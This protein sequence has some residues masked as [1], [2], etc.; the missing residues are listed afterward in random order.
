MP[1]D[2]VLQGVAELNITPFLTQLARLEAAV[3]TTVANVGI[4]M[5]RFSASINTSVAGMSKGVAGAGGLTAGLNKVATEAKKAGDTSKQGA[6]DAQDAYAG[7]NATLGEHAAELKRI[8]DQWNSIYRAGAQISQVAVTMGVLGGA[9]L[10]AAAATIQSASSVDFWVAKYRAAAQAA[11][12]FMDNEQDR[13]KAMQQIPEIIRNM[14]AETGVGADIIAEAA[15]RYQ[16]AA[17]T[18]IR[19]VKELQAQ[20]SGL[21]TLVKAS[22][23]ADTDLY[24]SVRG[25]TQIMGSFNMSANEMTRVTEV[26]SNAAQ[27]SNAEFQEFVESGKYGASVAHQLGVSF[28]EYIAVLAKLSE[29]GQRGTRAGRGLQMMLQ[30]IIDPSKEASAA[31]QQILVGSDNLDESWRDLIFPGGQFVGLMDSVNESG[32]KQLGL[33]GQLYEGTKNMTEAERQRFLATITTQNAY[34]VLMPMLQAYSQDLKDMA[35][36]AETGIKAETMSLE[37]LKDALSDVDERSRSFTE[38]WNTIS[39]SSRVEWSKEFQRLAA[40]IQQIGDVAHVALLPLVQNITDIAIGIRQW[41]IEN[42]QA[43]AT[44]A[45]LVTSISALLLVM[46]PLLFMLG[47]IFQGFVAV[48]GILSKASI[49]ILAILGDTVGIAVARFSVLG[50]AL[51]LLVNAWRNNW[52]GLTPVLNT[53]KNLIQDTIGVLA[54]SITGLVR[55]VIALFEGDWQKAWDIFV[56]IGLTAIALFRLYLGKL[57]LEMQKWGINLIG[58]LSTGLLE[59]A[60]TVL[61]AVLTAIGNM[62]ASFF[63]GFSPPKEGPLSDIDRWGENVMGAYADGIKR[64]AEKRIKPA[65]QDAAKAM[66]GPLEGHSPAKEGP[67]AEIGQWGSN[68]MD[69]ML[70]GFKKADFSILNEAA[71][72]V[73]DYLKSAVEAKQLSPDAFLSGMGQIRSAIASMLDGIRKGGELAQNAFDKIRSIVGGLSSDIENV[74]SAYKEVVEQERILDDLKAKSADLEARRKEEYD[75]PL[76][77]LRD[78]A[79]DLNILK[80]QYEDKKQA[81]QDN[82]DALERSK[83][84]L[85]DEKQLVDDGIEAYQE[86]LGV[87]EDAI[88]LLER[89]KQALEDQK[90]PIK[91]A[92]SLIRDEID[93]HRDVRD[94][95]QGRI[96]DLKYERRELEE[97]IDVIESRYDAENKAA[98]KIID[99]LRYQ[100]DILRDINDER[101]R[102]LKDASESAKDA[103]E[104]KRRKDKEAEEVIERRIAEY[105]ARGAAPR[106]IDQLEYQLQKMKFQ[107]EDEQKLLENQ[108]RAADSALDAAK[109]SAE[110]EENSLKRQLNEKERA[111][112]AAENAQRAIIEA[113]TEALYERVA[114]IEKEESTLDKKVKAI[115][116]EIDAAEKRIKVE[117][118]AEKNIDKQIAAVDKRI[119]AN[120]K[121]A[122]NIEDLMRPL[123]KQS[124]NIQ[125]Q[126]DNISDEQSNLEREKTIVD[127]QTK[128]IERRETAISR[129]EAL[130]EQRTRPLTDEIQLVKDQID[131]AETTLSKAQERLEIEQAIAKLH[132]DDRKEAESTAKSAA[133]G[134]GGAGGVGFDLMGADDEDP[135][136][137]LVK[138]IEEFAEEWKSKLLEQFSLISPELEEEK[139]K[140][141]EQMKDLFK[142]EFPKIEMPEW[143]KGIG[144]A[145][146]EIGRTSERGFDAIA[147]GAKLTEDAFENTGTTAKS[148]AEGLGDNLGKAGETIGDTMGNLGANIGSA[149]DGGVAELTRL[150]NEFRQ[151][152]QPL[153]DVQN[154]IRA[155]IGEMMGFIGENIGARMGSLG[156]QIG[157]QMGVIGE[158]V[159]S[160]M[161]GVGET[162]GNTL[163]KIGETLQPVVDEVG[164]QAGLMGE[165][166]GSAMGT[167]GEIIGKT[168]GTA[169][170]AIGSSLGDMGK[171]IEGKFK[172]WFGEGGVVQNWLDETKDGFIKFWS[173]TLPNAISDAWGILKEKIWELLHQIFGSGIIGDWFDDVKDGWD[174]FWSETIPEV[175]TGAWESLKSA[176]QETLGNMKTKVE[177]IFTGIKNFVVGP[178]GKTGLWGTF[179]DSIANLLGKDD[180][181]GLRKVWKAATDAFEKIKGV[182]EGIKDK[183]IGKDGNGGVLEDLRITFDNIFGE[184]KGIRAL[185][186]NAMNF[187]KE[188]FNKL[189]SPIKTVQGWLDDLAGAARS[190]WD[191]ATK[192]A[193]APQSNAGGGGGG[194]YGGWTGED[195]AR[196]IK[197]DSGETIGFEKVEWWP[198]MAS[199]GIVPGPVGKPRLIVAHGGEPFLGVGQSL[200]DFV[201]S[202]QIGV[203]Q[204]VLSGMTSVPASSPIIL[205][206]GTLVADAKGLEKLENTLKKFRDVRTERYIR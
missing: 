185:I 193:G 202:L 138:R 12:E 131:A 102:P 116:K 35:I 165:S 83:W 48:G 17:G 74:I 59:G 16:A 178:D 152:N 82:I 6:K 76:K 41:S 110:I 57:S 54:N 53:V 73:A 77:A 92:I 153:I 130:L 115:D 26:M 31:L 154:Q 114:A 30:G 47:Q 140:I 39:E 69:A 196:P 122:R 184:N 161:G 93:A 22:V 155:D 7:W 88:Y 176:V 75:K 173:E 34:R 36:E 177:E 199:G 20:L 120:T 172:E 149:V 201:S 180:T 127:D 132:E 2:V 80:F 95:I 164:R 78:E 27:V 143:L 91:E 187:L 182:F 23:V 145:F 204:A 96:D 157:T 206:V 15:F 18:Q 158:S 186:E 94:E 134:A 108:K 87:I 170:E 72:M 103:L 40:V 97:Q 62:I 60:R 38:Q 99:D 121:E 113:E 24:E 188:Q 205:Q 133:G 191:W 105:R 123:Q 174:K 63:K 44:I 50:A 200:Q 126:I 46:S 142:I 5:Q 144:D 192:A 163:G 125:K 160:T 104:E 85:E 55:I 135:S 13:A 166:I 137:G 66:S 128:W 42:P 52:L 194:G 106:F 64:G 169:G 61:T 71:S 98:K 148:L 21:N 119:D 151:L 32:E 58:S 101:L 79:A 112:K 86:K 129:E 183:L 100:L 159:G 141:R 4:A 89:E 197:D 175:L 45:T 9:I 139:K 33:I 28:E 56:D 179:T 1:N 181:G 118:K 150:D 90:A 198:S 10:G 25:V 203:S 68:L 43:S 162:I 147:L 171:E 190:A 111:Q 136:T 84:P 156:E 81:I 8:E 117:E 49:P 37:E 146:G 51:V 109:D 189:E 70:R 65:A 14:A 67:L 29:Y 168:M 167:A 19:S 195:Y 11:G 124:E 3:N 107:H